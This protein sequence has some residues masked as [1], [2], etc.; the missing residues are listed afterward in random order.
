MRCKGNRPGSKAY[1]TEVGR[2]ND[3]RRL[4]PIYD[5]TAPIVCTLTSGEVQERRALLE[6]LRTVLEGIDRTEHGLLLQVPAEAGVDA[7]L[8]H[9]V[10]VEKQCCQFWGFDVQQ[11][12]ATVTLR[13]DAPPAAAGLVAQLLAW[14][15]GDDSIDPIGLL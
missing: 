11:A 13:W 4:I 7:E 6:R 14:F 12:P 15:Q 5:A 10:Q 8:R 1:G 9:F 3:D 2:F